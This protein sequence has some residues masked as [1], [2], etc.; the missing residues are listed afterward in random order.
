MITLRKL[1]T[2]ALA[3][4]DPAKTVSG[5]E[6]YRALPDSH[7]TGAD[8][9]SYG[10]VIHTHPHLQSVP[11][12]RLRQSSTRTDKAAPPA[13]AFINENT[14]PMS[15]PIPQTMTSVPGLVTMN[16]Q[17]SII[18]GGGIKW[19]LPP[20]QYLEGKEVN[21]CC[22]STTYKPYKEQIQ[23]EIRDCCG[24][25]TVKRT[26]FIGPNTDNTD[27]PTKCCA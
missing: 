20:G 9:I 14:A 26:L 16:K 7:D 2:I 6:N 22:T 21:A 19:T 23:V 27:L 24:G 3:M 12:R 17:F 25:G 15:P 5:H 11:R 4:Q 8:T 1:V 10:N 18:D 13:P